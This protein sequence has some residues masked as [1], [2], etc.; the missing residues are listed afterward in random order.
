[1]EFTPVKILLLRCL[2]QRLC[3]NIVWDSR[4]FEVKRTIGTSLQFMCRHDFTEIVNIFLI[5]RLTLSNSL[6]CFSMKG[7]VV[8]GFLDKTRT[9]AS[10]Y[11]QRRNSVVVSNLIIIEV[12]DIFCVFIEIV[13]HTC[14]FR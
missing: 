5:L 4:R 12:Y 11:F 1:M 8:N 13:L 10:V 7:T 3:F 2:D 9:V 14:Y 6:D